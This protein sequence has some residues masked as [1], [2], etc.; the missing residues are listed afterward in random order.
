M[1]KKDSN[2]VVARVRVC[3]E[4]A[5][6]GYASRTADSAAHSGFLDN[7]H[8]RFPW[9]L[10]MRFL[11]PILKSVAKFFHLLPRRV[12]PLRKDS[13]PHV[14]AAAWALGVTPS[15]M[16]IFFAD[17]AAAAGLHD[18]K[19]TLAFRF[20]PGSHRRPVPR[21]VLKYGDG[22]LS[23]PQ[24]VSVKWRLCLPVSVFVSASLGTIT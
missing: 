4:F 16:S 1:F 5:F 14:T 9:S 11:I 18:I 12:C 22:F 7:G 10:D 17:A 24:Y 6:L 2:L 13:R 15:R 20:F 8:N 3:R 19:F 21:P 23:P